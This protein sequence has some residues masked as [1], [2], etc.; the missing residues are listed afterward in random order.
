MLHA[1]EHFVFCFEAAM[2]KPTNDSAAAQPETDFQYQEQ[3]THGVKIK[4]LKG[5]RIK[6]KLQQF[7]HYHTN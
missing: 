6:N 1:L 3:Y 7:N 2:F 5:L 4:T